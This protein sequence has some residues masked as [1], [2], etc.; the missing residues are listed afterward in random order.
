MKSFTIHPIPLFVAATYPA[1][2][3]RFGAGKAVPLGWFVWYIE[4][5]R[6]KILVDTGI[7]LEQL[8]AAEYSCPR[9]VQTLD[10]GLAKL[11]LKPEGIDLVIQTHLHVDHTAYMKRFTRAKF[12]VQKRELEYQRNPPPPALDPRPFNKDLIGSLDWEVVDGDYS[13]EDGLEVLL[14][15]GHT[16][17][18]QSVAVDTARGKAVIVGLC[19][20]DETF[21]PPEAIKDAAPVLV[22]GILNDPRQAYDSLLRLKKLADI[23]IPIH[24]VRFAFV[25]SVP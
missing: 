17:G 9:Q 4:G 10:G 19:S 2:I 13:I 15:P 3:Y 16:P 7:T 12:L 22:P 25:S 14:T 6:R 20:T 23:L 11:G 5:P 1:P 24:E 8:L 21:Q 18:T